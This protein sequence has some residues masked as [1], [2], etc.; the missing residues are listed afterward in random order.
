MTNNNGNVM[1]DIDENTSENKLNKFWCFF[2]CYS[3]VKQGVGKMIVGLCNCYLHHP[4]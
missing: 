2:Q 3:Y 1:I 4:P